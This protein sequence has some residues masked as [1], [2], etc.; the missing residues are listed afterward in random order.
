MLCEHSSEQA[1]L[2]ACSASRTPSTKN[3]LADRAQEKKE[4]QSDLRLLEIDRKTEMTTRDGMLFSSAEKNNDKYCPPT[5]ME[6]KPA[7]T[8]D[9]QAFVKAENLYN[10]FLE[11]ATRIFTSHH[12]MVLQCSW[13][14]LNFPCNATSSP[15]MLSASYTDA[16]LCFMFQHDPEWRFSVVPW[17]PSLTPTRDLG[18]LPEWRVLWICHPAINQTDCR[19]ES[20]DKIGQIVESMGFVQKKYKMGGLKGIDDPEFLSPKVGDPLQYECSYIGQD[21]RLHFV[22]SRVK[23]ATK[24]LIKR[25]RGVGGADMYCHHYTNAHAAKEID[26]YHFVQGAQQKGINQ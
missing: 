2:Q 21:R 19:V 24:I 13:K 23:M 1:A 20:L 25:E 6:D 14:G 5:D 26:Q 15:I 10:E 4:N 7:E 17:Q 9:F 16:G 8:I 22:V 11:M 12:D 3:F 18:W